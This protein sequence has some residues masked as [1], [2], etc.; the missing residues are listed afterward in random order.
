MSKKTPQQIRQLVRRGTM[1]LQRGRHYQAAEV[2]E[3][4]YEQDP[5]NFDAAL[6]L[7]AA[8][9][10]GKK[11]KDAIPILE[12]LDLADPDNA[13]VYTNLGAAYLG[14]PVLAKD[15][16]QHKAIRAFKRSLDIDPT[17]PNIAYNIGLIYR[18]RRNWATAIEWFG[19]AL[20]H[21]PND[22]DAQYWIDQLRT[23]LD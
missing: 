22:A 8:Y 10:K 18:D 17:A 20:K 4:A 6:N 2:L 11:F 19:T 3:R 9:I 15:E 14:N 12:K 23:K 16:A 13:M 21:N 7:S 5:D 1:L